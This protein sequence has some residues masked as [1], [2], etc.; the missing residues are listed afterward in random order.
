MEYR[1]RNSSD[2]AI[3]TPVGD[4]QI[5][6]PEVLT[7]RWGMGM[8]KTS[9]GQSR[10]KGIKMNARECELLL[11]VLLLFA[12]ASAAVAEDVY[13]DSSHTGLELGTSENPFTSV[14]MALRHVSS[15]DTLYVK[16][17]YE[18]PGPVT[19]SV[20]VT[21]KAWQ[22]SP[23][24]GVGLGVLLHRIYYRSLPLVWSFNPE[25]PEWNAAGVSP[26]R[27]KEIFVAPY[28]LP[29]P[30]DVKYIFFFSAGQQ[31]ILN[32]CVT[33]GQ[34]DDWDDFPVEDTCVFRL[35]NNQSIAGQIITQHTDYPY[36]PENT[37]L[38]L[39][40]RGLDS[41]WADHEEQEK[42]VQGYHDWLA[43]KMS[44]FE[45]VELVYLC[46]ASRGGALAVR[47]GR[48]IRELHSYGPTDQ[49][50]PKI[51]IS[52]LDGVADE[53]QQVPGQEEGELMT[54]SIEIPNPTDTDWPYKF[55]HYAIWFGDDGFFGGDL[56]RSLKVYQI[57]GEGLPQLPA[58]G[59]RCFVS[60]L[61]PA[62][63]GENPVNSAGGFYSHKWVNLDHETIC[64][65][66]HEDVTP[67]H[68]AWFFIEGFGENSEDEP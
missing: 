34:Y 50:R 42:I 47:L 66:W 68:L 4:K 40:F 59:Q 11:A 3:I 53:N 35:L 33:T 67:T 37:L 32:P 62:Q 16:G 51:L 49:V 24:I 54:T 63:A 38:L 58:V 17:P 14:Q 27:Q 2:F 21:V 52:C 31:A 28:W 6:R 65:A 9:H 8:V 1:K 12:M 20:P 22:D 48:R 29:R 7:R 10:I 55:G 5:P 56:S 64:N 60:G 39:A 43:G 41:I 18:Y 44:N 26:D 36:G 13:V 30:A 15:G 61:T 46:G 25:F 57:M 23:T 19:F 45:N